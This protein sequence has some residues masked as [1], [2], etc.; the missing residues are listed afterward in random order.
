LA[1]ARFHTV[2]GA[3]GD[4]VQ[5]ASGSGS[6]T[7]AFGAFHGAETL[8]DNGSTSSGNDTVYDFSQS[9]GDRISLSNQDNVVL[10]VLT[11]TSDGSGNV[12][13]HLHDGSS[14]TLIGVAQASLNT[15]YFTTH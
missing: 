14:I 4:T 11:A 7:I 10:V 1:H 6:A 2:S 12:V 3:S 9:T 15:G 8:W 13:V 5:G